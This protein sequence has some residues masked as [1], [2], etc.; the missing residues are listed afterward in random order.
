MSMS[1][2]VEA[3]APTQESR[4][5]DVS[6]H[7]LRTVISPCPQY[8]ERRLENITDV[9][10]HRVLLRILQIFPDALKCH[11]HGLPSRFVRDSQRTSP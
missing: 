8:L 4:H 3:G 2:R 9:Q 6:F 11:F 10:V 1:M 7:R 5:G